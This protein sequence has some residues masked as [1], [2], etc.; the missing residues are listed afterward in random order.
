[1]DEHRMKSNFIKYIEKAS[2]IVKTWPKWKQNLL[3]TYTE[4]KEVNMSRAFTKEEVRKMFLQNVVS[5]SDYWGN[6]PDKTDL[7]RAQGVAF[8][9]LVM[10][11]GESS[12]VPAMDIVLRPHPDDEEYHKTEDT[13]WF[14]NGMV[15]NEEEMHHALCQLEATEVAE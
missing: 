15:I 12:V 6:L 9:M 5:I 4:K 2:E 1:M 10:F 3:G 14:E 8:S 7:E 11:D 13:N